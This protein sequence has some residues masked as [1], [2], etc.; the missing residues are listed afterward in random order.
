MGLISNA[1]LIVA[2]IIRAIHSRL[3]SFHHVLIKKK[4][5]TNVAIKTH[6][7]NMLSLNNIVQKFMSHPL[8]KRQVGCKFNGVITADIQIIQSIL[9]I[10]DHITFHTHISYFFLMIAAN[11]AATSGREVHAAMIVAQIARSETQKFWAINTAAST[12]KSEAKTRIHKLAISFAKFNIIHKSF[13]L[14]FHLFLE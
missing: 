9:N 14:D 7:E 10:S 2:R 5:N 8:A 13:S 6:T 12:T 4:V 3:D 1:I 11:V